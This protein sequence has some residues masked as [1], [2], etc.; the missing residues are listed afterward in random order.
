MIE[1]TIAE[2]GF[3]HL[4][5]GMVFGAILGVALSQLFKL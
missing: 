3:W 2:Y 4:L 5:I 1:V